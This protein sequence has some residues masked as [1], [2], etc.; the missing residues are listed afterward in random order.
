MSTYFGG[1]VSDE[2]EDIQSRKSIDKWIF[3]LLMGL[4]G[5]MP[6]IILASMEE[7]VS[8]LISS[9]NTLQSGMKG[10]LFTH[11]KS[12][13]LLIITIVVSIMLLVKLFFMNGTIR[14]SPINYLLGIFGIA[15]I[16]S[17]IMS[18]NITI[19][20][21][22]QY[23]RSDG[24]ITWL[25][26]LT[27]MF[28]V[29]NIDFPKYFV[30]SIM[31]TMMPF[32]FINLYII[33]MNFYGNDLLRKE[34]VQRIVTSTLPEGSALTEGSVLLGTLNQWNYMSGMFGILTILYLTAA[35]IIEK[36]KAKY[37]Y[38]IMSLLTMAILLM[39]M[40]ASG[41]FT[42]ICLIPFIIW[43]VIKSN[44][45]VVTTILFLIFCI[46]SV[47][48]I[49]ILSQQDPKVW[50][51]SIGFFYKGENPYAETINNEVSSLQNNSKSDSGFFI[52]NAYASDQPLVL[53]VL[54]EAAWTAGTGRIYIWKETLELV[55][56]RPL[57]GYGLDSLLYHFPHYNLEAQA[58]LNEFTIVDKPHNIYMGV[59]Y[60]TGF[61]GFIAFLG[62]VL[63]SLKGALLTII[64]PNSIAVLAM[65]W[66]A[67]LIQALFN[68]TTPAIMA[69]VFILAG[70]IVNYRGEE[71]IVKDR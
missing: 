15:I 51:E 53:P 31:Y 41:F 4:I 12:L 9:I 38:L 57:F 63:F 55:A 56:D 39:A 68:D 5:V 70:I 60:G 1:V 13:F 42:L 29:M 49:H 26:Y 62:I 23:N 20:L 34:W 40:S 64:R 3:R 25:C 43:F 10:E 65:A 6:L 71:T 7:V 46:M 28:V 54:P 24:A 50:N 32:V 35:I 44:K 27:L 14:K 58:N 69:I 45:K 11:F 61:L 36:G 19:A 66:L 47:G 16:V 67:F 17:T 22:G 21:N 33:T 37:I 52:S 2:E 18:P 59:L 30:H 48:E 8:P